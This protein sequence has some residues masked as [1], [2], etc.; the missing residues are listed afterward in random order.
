MVGQC[1]HRDEVHSRLGIGAEGGVGDAAAGLGL[2]AHGPGL[3]AAH[4]LGEGRDVEVVEHDAV[5]TAVV[6]H[7][8]Q[9]VQVAHL[10]FDFQRLALVVQVLARTVDGRLDAAGE[11][12]VIVLEHHHVVEADT[13][14]GAAAAGHGILLQQP[15][16]GGRLAGVEQSGLQPVQ[17]LHHAAGLGGD[18]GEALHEVERRALGGEDAAAVPLD[19][20]QHIALGH[21]LDVVL[22]EGDFQRAVDQHE[23]PLA[24]FGAAEDAL[25]LGHHLGSALGRRRDA[26]QGGVVAVA[27]V[28]AQGRFYQLVK[29]RN[30][31]H[32]YLDVLYIHLYRGPPWRPG[33]ICK[34]THFF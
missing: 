26:R 21:V 2:V 1:A 5:H 31:H 34:Y 32:N 7:A 30:L 27:H 28:L 24:H 6:E 3:D 25:L 9:L 19:G 29:I 23:H 16:V 17:H 10:D 14:V 15:H 18:A 13:V 33:S 20:H 11:V 4:G 12:D 8:L 22:E